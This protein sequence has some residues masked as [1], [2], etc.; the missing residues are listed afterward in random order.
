MTDRLVLINP[1]TFALYAQGSYITVYTLAF[2]L[3]SPT[4]LEKIRCSVY[5]CNFGFKE[6]LYIDD[7]SIIV[8]AAIFES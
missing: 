3:S 8:E 2:Q 4:F 7:K 5:G 6:D 1:L